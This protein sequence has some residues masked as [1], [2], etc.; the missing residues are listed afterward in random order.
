MTKTQE[1]IAFAS[2]F[3]F[4][5]TVLMIIVLQLINIMEMRQVVFEASIEKA[6]EKYQWKKDR[7]RTYTDLVYNTKYGAVYEK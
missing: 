4:L 5:I 7:L 3:L 6:N 1:V 2:P